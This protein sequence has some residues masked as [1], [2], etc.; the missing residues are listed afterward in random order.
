MTR[1]EDNERAV[2][3]LVEDAYGG[4][5][6]GLDDL[7]AKD[8]RDHSRWVDREGLRKMLAGFRAAYPD[9]CF[10]VTKLVA[11]G[12]EEAAR[13]EC[14]CGGAENA[15]GKH[16]GAIAIFKFANGKLIEH[17]AHSDSFF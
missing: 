12:D 15:Q 4:D 5:L 7:V 9:V 1:N 10:T 6:D 16:F 11:E 2:R 8:C 17:W 13:Y 14:E 3:R